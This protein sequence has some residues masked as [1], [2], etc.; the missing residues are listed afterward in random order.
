MSC[1]CHRRSI[2]SLSIGIVGT[3]KAARRHMKALSRADGARI[4]ACVDEDLDAAAE[5]AVKFPGAGAYEVLDAMLEEHDVDAVYLSD[6]P[7]EGGEAELALIERG[8]PFFIEKPLGV[9]RE[10]PARVMDALRGT[11]L[12]TGVGYVLRYGDTVE[13]ARAHLSEN[14]PVLARGT[15]L[16]GAPEP[17]NTNANSSGVLPG[18]TSHL[19][20]LVRYL[21]GEVSRVYCAGQGAN[22]AGEVSACTLT[23]ES[24]LVCQISS[25]RSAPRDEVT[26]EVVTADSTLQLCG[27]NSTCRI[28]SA[29]RMEEVSGTADLFLAQTT[30]FLNAVEGDAS[31]LKSTYQDAYRTHLVCCAAHESMESGQPVEL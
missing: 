19:L 29:H 21:L 12:V 1:T 7:G 9:D 11:D 5:A 17:A 20:D 2:V 10:K 3:G 31:G 27:A 28:S 4:V 13:R 26:F 24:G 16:G 23:F 8:I 25:S 6:R 18:R 14:S 15:C 30:A 22:A